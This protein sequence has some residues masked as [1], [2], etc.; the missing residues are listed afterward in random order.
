MCKQPKLYSQC[1]I[2]LC[3]ISAALAWKGKERKKRKVNILHVQYRHVCAIVRMLAIQ[4]NGICV[5]SFQIQLRPL[6]CVLVF[7]F[8]HDTPIY[9]LF[10][11]CKMAVVVHIISTSGC[12]TVALHLGL[13]LPNICRLRVEWNWNVEYK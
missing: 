11:S 7:M 3:L 12:M 5:H 6:R 10:T 4:C 1:L 13:G 8:T 2:L 9:N